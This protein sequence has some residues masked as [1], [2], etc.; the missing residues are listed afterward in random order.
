MIF[1]AQPDGE[2]L[3]KLIIENKNI[4]AAVDLLVDLVT[5]FRQPFNGSDIQKRYRNKDDKE[6]KNFVKAVKANNWARMTVEV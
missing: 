5:V 4:V 6:G 3:I 1:L 2:K